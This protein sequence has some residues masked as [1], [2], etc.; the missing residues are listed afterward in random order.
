MNS[1][2]TR[3]VKCSI[4][5][6]QNFQFAVFLE[7]L[8]NRMVHQAKFNYATCLEFKALARKNGPAGKSLTS[9][10]MPRPSSS[11]YR[12]SPFSL[13]PPNPT[14]KST[15]ISQTLTLPIYFNIS[16]TLKLSQRYDIYPYT[17]RICNL[18]V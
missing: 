2:I 14:A 18:Y 1:P 9:Y 11:S 10:I 6:H 3:R 15:S 13:K 17:I 7:Y 8:A 12:F 16:T 4:L 5:F